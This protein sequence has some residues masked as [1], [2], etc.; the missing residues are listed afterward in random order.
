MKMILLQRGCSYLTKDDRSASPWCRIV[1]QDANSHVRFSVYTFQT[2]EH[3]D[4]TS[5]PVLT[6]TAIKATNN[7]I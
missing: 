2:I 7:N 1:T 3:Q 6:E 5:D 4:T